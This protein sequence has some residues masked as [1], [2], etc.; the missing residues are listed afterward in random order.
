MEAAAAVELTAAEVVVTVLATEAAKVRR[1]GTGG[2]VACS[3]N[4]SSSGSRLRLF[5]AS[6]SLR[7]FGLMVWATAVHWCV[8]GRA[9]LGAIAPLTLRQE[10][11]GGT[12]ADTS[13]SDLVMR[14]TSKSAGVGDCGGARFVVSTCS[15]LLRLHVSA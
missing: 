6:S 14:S 4:G 13:S 2:M 7:V 8:K 1:K 15:S 10:S 11:T 5:H 9:T 3:A 12:D